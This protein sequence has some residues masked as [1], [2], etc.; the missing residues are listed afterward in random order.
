MYLPE[1]FLL[2][3]EQEDETDKST[4][5]RGFLAIQTGFNLRNA[6]ALREGE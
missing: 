5:T 4:V 3:G 1:N 6:R 2:Y